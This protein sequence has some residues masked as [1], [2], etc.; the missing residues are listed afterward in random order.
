MIKRD[1]YWDTLKFVLIFFVVCAHTFVVHSPDGSFNRALY[2]FICL[3]AMPMFIFVSGRFSHIRDID[4]YKLGLLRIFETYIVFQVIRS[5]IL[6][7]HRDPLSF[8]SILTYLLMPTYTLWYL[9]C[10]IYWRLLVMLIP[11]KILSE[12]PFAILT[13]C[14]AISILGGFIPVRILSLQRAMTF[15]PFFFLGYYSTEIDLRKWLSKI[16][17]GIPVMSVLA[18]FFFLYYFMNFDFGFVHHGKL[19][20][21]SYPSLSPLVLCAARC[22]FILVAIILSVMIMRL[23]RVQPLMA[24][25]GG[26]TLAI[27]IFHSFIVQGLKWF[28]KRGYL[29]DNEI[30][31]FIYTVV[32]TLG[33]AYLSRFKIVKIMLNPIT[34][35]KERVKC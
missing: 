14:F 4:K 16:H 12:K 11:K 5:I 24:K 28:V 23:V 17:I 21:W 6:L 10:I 13:L 22:L 20:Y 18:L 34:Y 2:S 33:L 29:P 9:V 8:H 1:L 31:L 7:L 26:A 32:I 25:M 3:F 27:Y 19:S 15:L 35:I 30:C